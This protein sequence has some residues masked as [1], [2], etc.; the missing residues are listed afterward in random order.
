[1]CCLGT[2]AHFGSFQFR[3]RGKDQ[4]D[5]AGP[6]GRGPCRAGS[7]PR[8]LSASIMPSA[9]QALSPL[10]KRPSGGGG[11]ACTHSGA[12][13]QTLHSS[14][15]CMRRAR[16]YCARS[17]RGAAPR[18]KRCGCGPSASSA[19]WRR[20]CPSACPRGPSEPAPSA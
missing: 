7:P 12:P 9:I 16:P 11:T 17:P 5:K 8:S 4:G 20:R 1:M 18:P 10:G 19:R 3:S 2:E 14:A 13:T 6:R 15:S